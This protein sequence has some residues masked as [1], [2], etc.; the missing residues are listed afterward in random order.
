[1]LM[2][3]V[4]AMGSVLMVLVT[5][6]GWVLMVLLWFRECERQGSQVTRMLVLQLSASLPSRPA[7]RG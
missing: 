5:A 4:T 6:M 3:L 7:G 2:V 1:M